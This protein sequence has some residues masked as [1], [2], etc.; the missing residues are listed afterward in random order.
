MMEVDGDVNGL[1]NHSLNQDDR[2][3]EQQHSQETEHK[4]KKKHHGNRKLQR[5][6]RKLR[7]Q[8][9]KL[10]TMTSLEAPSTEVK[11]ENARETIEQR[12]V[13]IAPPVYRTSAIAT[14]ESTMNRG[15]CLCTLANI[16]IH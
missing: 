7:A 4:N 6:R 16:C 8:A 13:S 15:K 14:G 10:H 12:V 2:V 1:L 5:Y 11:S 3:Q 9:K